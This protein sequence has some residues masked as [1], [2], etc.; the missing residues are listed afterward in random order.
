MFSTTHPPPMLF[1]HSPLFLSLVQGLVSNW[2]LFPCC[3]WST[4]CFKRPCVSLPFLCF[5]CYPHLFHFLSAFSS[6]CFRHLHPLIHLAFIL[7][8][9]VLKTRLA[10]ESIWRSLVEVFFILYLLLHSSRSIVAF[11]GAS[12]CV[13]VCVSACA[14]HWLLGHEDD[15]SHWTSV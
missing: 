7:V 11:N 6:I 14:V 2:T 12:A 1:Y 10:K 15:Y 4:R 9:F 13:S 3:T 8:I 5:P